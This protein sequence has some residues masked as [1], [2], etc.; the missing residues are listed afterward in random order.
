MKD[1]M[2]GVSDRLFSEKEKD[3]PKS[4]EDQPDPKPGERTP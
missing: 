4:K 1:K 3:I 2:G